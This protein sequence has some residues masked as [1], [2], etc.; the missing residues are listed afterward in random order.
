VMAQ[1]HDGEKNFRRL[2]R[3]ALDGMLPGH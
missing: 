1:A 3:R 2:V